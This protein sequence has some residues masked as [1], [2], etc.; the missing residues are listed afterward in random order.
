[1]ADSSLIVFILAGLALN[2]TPGPDMMFIITKSVAGSTR[3]GVVSSLGIA[4]GSLVHTL[5][6][7]FGFSAVLMAVPAA[8][9][10][11]K[12]TGAAYLVYLGVKVFFS[13]KESVKDETAKPAKMHSIFV[14][15]LLTNI[16]NPKVALFFLAFIPQFITPGQN[17]TTQFIL[18]GLLFNFNGTVV[19]IIV[20]VISGRLGSSLKNKLKNSAVFKWISASVFIG[21][22]LRLALLERK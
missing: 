14:Q 11:I 9:E 19:N 5:L 16:F 7:A 4:S 12:Y 20:A 15:A 18:L 2:I 8:Y 10:I 21:L 22:G 6:A 13:K 1:M 17:V 3:S